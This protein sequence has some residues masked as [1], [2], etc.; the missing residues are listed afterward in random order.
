MNQIKKNKYRINKY[1]VDKMRK[2][3][4][5]ELNNRNYLSFDCLE[6]GV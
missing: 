1:V 3:L 6:I 4:S 5:Y 2:E